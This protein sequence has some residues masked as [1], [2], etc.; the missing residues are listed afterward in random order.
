MEN[1]TTTVYVCFTTGSQE[2]EKIMPND[3]EVLD[4]F[5]P[6]PLNDYLSKYAILII[7]LSQGMK[8]NLIPRNPI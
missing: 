5:F 7:V 2:V 6:P 1:A 8:N 3:C 4:F